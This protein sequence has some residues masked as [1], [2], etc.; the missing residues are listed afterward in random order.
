MIEF[1]KRYPSKNYTRLCLVIG[2]IVFIGIYSYMLKLFQVFGFSQEE[3]NAVF[4]SFDV[5]QFRG[6]IQTV[7]QSDQMS[8]FKNVFIINIF[9]ISAFMI[10]FYSLSVMIARS[11]EATSKLY[12]FAYIFPTFPIL[13]AFFDIMPS[14]CIIATSIFT[15]TMFPVWLAYV[16]SGGYV[17]R[18]ILL[19][20]LVIWFLFALIRFIIRKLKK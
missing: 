20:L 6:L 14:I 2:L 10:A 16:V 1:F 13:I 18:V 12:K 15:L 9:S 8:V 4:M 3:F 17:I 7:I 19:Y 5:V 11:I